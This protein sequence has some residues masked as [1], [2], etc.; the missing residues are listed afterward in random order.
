MHDLPI[1]LATAIVSLIPAFTVGF[2]AAAIVIVLAER[3]PSVRAAR[4]ETPK[5]P[6]WL[7]TLAVFVGLVAASAMVAG[8]FT[9]ALPRETQPHS[10]RDE[11][12]TMRLVVQVCGVIGGILGGWAACMLRGRQKPDDER[13]P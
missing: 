10:Q 6:E 9:A 3:L 13:V 2:V 1:I 7:R 11:L 5:L 8:A 4:V 12:Q